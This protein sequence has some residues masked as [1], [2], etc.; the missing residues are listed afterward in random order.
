VEWESAKDQSVTV[1]LEI[2]T[3]DRQGMLARITQVL[4]AANSNIRSIEARTS[5]DGRATIDASVTTQNRRHLEKLLVGLRALPGV[6]DVR[7]K[8]RSSD[9]EAG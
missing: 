6:T 3:E 7:R 4:S 5:G 1:E 2:R 8:L 9:A